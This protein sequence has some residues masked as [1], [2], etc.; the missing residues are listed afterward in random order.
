MVTAP[1]EIGCGYLPGRKN[2]CLYLVDG[3]RITPLAWFTDGEAFELWRACNATYSY[4]RLQE[5]AA[6]F[7]AG[8]YP[9]AAA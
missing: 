8:R 7:T 9:E 6:G 2:P 5:A 1:A 4:N 3:G